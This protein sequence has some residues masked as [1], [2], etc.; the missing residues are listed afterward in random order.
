MP[1]VIDKRTNVFK[2]PWTDEED[3]TLLK[4][5][6]DLT[7][8]QWCRLGSSVAVSPVD[9]LLLSPTQGG[10]ERCGELVLRPWLFEKQ[11]ALHGKE[12]SNSAGLSS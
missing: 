10:S 6:D 9:L 4:L 2:G 12:L 7:H 8:L 11:G 1:R 5:L 3:A